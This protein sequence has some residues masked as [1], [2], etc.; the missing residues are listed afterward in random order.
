MGLIKQGHDTG[1][2]RTQAHSAQFSRP[3]RAPAEFSF[4][5]RF[6]RQAVLLLQ[7]FDCRTQSTAERKAGG[8]KTRKELRFSVGKV[9]PLGCR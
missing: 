6:Q 3:C 4:S 1:L 5:R 2:L 8:V 7:D 9:F